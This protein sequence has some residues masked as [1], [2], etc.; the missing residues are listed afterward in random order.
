MTLPA[1]AMPRA[2]RFVLLVTAL[3]GGEAPA[4]DAGACAVALGLLGAGLVGGR[5]A[6]SPAAATG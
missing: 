6:E 4:H 2:R 1:A 5:T 3:I